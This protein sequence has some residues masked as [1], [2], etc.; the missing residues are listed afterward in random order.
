MVLT[1][2]IDGLSDFDA[3]V[4]GQDAIEYGGPDC[5]DDD[6]TRYYD[7]TG[8]DVVEILADLIDEN[9]NGQELCYIDADWDG[10]GNPQGTYDLSTSIDCTQTGF[11]INTDDCD[12]GNGNRYPS[13]QRFATVSV[14]LVVEP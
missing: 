7:P 4:D 11:S 6:P 10:Y 9:C 8:V 5:A 13:A 14:M 12:D 2:I 3:D 1:K